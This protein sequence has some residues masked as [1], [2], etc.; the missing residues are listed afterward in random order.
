M[1]QE[2]KLALVAANSKFV[3][4]SSDDDGLVAHSITAGPEQILKI[5]CFK[6]VEEVDAKRKKTPEEE[7]G[8]VEQIEINYV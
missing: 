1:L 7:L 4:I 2:G 5:R 6:E 3:S 8:S